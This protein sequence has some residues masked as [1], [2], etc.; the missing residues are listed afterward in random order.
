MESMATI[1]LSTASEIRGSIG[2][3]VYS[4]NKGGAY[5][6]GRV[7]PVNPVSD[8]RE[9]V[10]GA[11]TAASQAWSSLTA[12]QRQGWA[13]YGATVGSVNRVGDAIEL[14]GM[15][16]YARSRL[17]MITAGLSPVSDPPS[18]AIAGNPSTVTEA[19]F[20]LTWEVDKYEL[21]IVAFEVSLESGE[22]YYVQQGRPA[23]VGVTYYKAPFVLMGAETS[24]DEG[25]PLVL[26]PAAGQ[27]V[28]FR[29]RRVTADGRVGP[30]AIYSRIA[31][32]Q[33]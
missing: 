1:K 9:A 33:V 23:S 20:A 6:R 29:V 17:A 4:R 28:F 27:R 18:Q 7:S 22:A 30:S 2:G 21:S 19:N 26:V 8:R 11:M 15:A 3:T 16:A 5:I 13:D 31:P 10:K 24:E 32:A 12:G 25:L 14:S